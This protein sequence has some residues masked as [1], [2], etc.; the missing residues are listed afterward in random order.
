M[1]KIIN[2]LAF[3]A[4]GVVG[5]FFAWNAIEDAWTENV[6]KPWDRWKKEREEANEK[7]RQAELKEQ[8]EARRAARLKK[9]EEILSKFNIDRTK[10]GQKPENNNVDMGCS[11]FK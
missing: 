6:T 8:R 5:A 7:L 4:L 10:I 1:Q 9:N 3:A 11:F 2:K